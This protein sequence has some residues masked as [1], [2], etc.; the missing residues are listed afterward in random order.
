MRA[1]SSIVIG[2][3]P[4]LIERFKIMHLFTAR[5]KGI[6]REEDNN[7]ISKESENSRK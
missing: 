4:F 7:N 5:R 6:Q 1:N 2:S 3:L